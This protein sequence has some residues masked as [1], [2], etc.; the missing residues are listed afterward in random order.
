MKG[1]EWTKAAVRV[2]V[3][4]GLRSKRLVFDRMSV[5]AEVAGPFATHE[6]LGRIPA[7]HPVTLTHSG[8]GLRVGAFPD[9]DQ[10]RRV[11]GE[12]LDI[13]P[14]SGW[15]FED[16]VDFERSVPASVRQALSDLVD[17]RGGVRLSQREIQDILSNAREA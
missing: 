10:A 7:T 5:P 6:S 9:V 8:S 17:H 1:I 11:A 12:L 16:L 3:I 2:A 13:L 15:A 4:R 14:E